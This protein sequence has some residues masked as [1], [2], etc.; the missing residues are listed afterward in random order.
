M[1]CTIYRHTCDQLHYNLKVTILTCFQQCSWVAVLTDIIGFCFSFKV[2]YNVIS[3]VAGSCRVIE[4][5]LTQVKITALDAA[6][7]AA[8]MT[9]DAPAAT[10]L[11]IAIANPR[12]RLAGEGKWMLVIRVLHRKRLVHY[13]RKIGE[14]S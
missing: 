13:E 9:I 14:G 3:D 8:T 1:Y 7:A 12:G 2:R 5:L 10:K 4:A 11:R 6:V